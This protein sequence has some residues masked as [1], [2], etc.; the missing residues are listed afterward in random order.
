M[1]HVAR[2]ALSD[3]IGRNPDYLRFRD[4]L[5]GEAFLKLVEVVRKRPDATEGYVFVAVMRALVEY[6]REIPTFSI[7]RKTVADCERDGRDVPEL[8][9]EAPAYELDNVETRDATGEDVEEL[10]A[11]CRDDT[12]R[13]IVELK[14]EGYTTEEI[15]EEL[16]TTKGTVSKRWAK[17]VRRFKR[18]E[19]N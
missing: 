12:D 11:C 4:D 15:G 1:L 9:D 14:D 13:G 5:Q 2:G 7:P 10:L 19:T 3:F 16:G 18:R 8:P 6:A 17:I